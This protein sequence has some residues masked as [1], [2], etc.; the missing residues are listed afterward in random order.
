MTRFG[1]H[2]VLGAMTAFLVIA[3][4]GGD[5]SGFEDESGGDNVTNGGGTGG[6]NGSGQA[7]GSFDTEVAPTDPTDPTNPTAPTEVCATTHA[8]LSGKAH[9]IVLVLDR[10][11]S[12]KDPISNGSA[13]KWE[14]IQSAFTGFFKSGESTSIS[15]DVIPFPAVVQSSPNG[16][17]GY[18]YEKPAAGLST[19]LP[20]TSGAFSSTFSKIGVTGS[21]PT[22]AAMQGAI[23][24][25][26]A[27][28]KQLAGSA[29]VSIV[30]ATDGLPQG[31]LNKQTD[32]FF[33]ADDVAKTVAAGAGTVK[34]YVVGIGDQLESLNKIASAGGT[35][36][37]YLITGASTSLPK[38]LSKALAA[39]RAAAIG[40]TYNMPTPPQ[41]KTL[42]K[43]QVNVVYEGDKG[44]V[45]VKHSADCA[46]PNGWH[47]DNESAPT[48]ILLCGGACGTVKAA[49][50]TS[51]D[52]VLGCETNSPAAI[53][54]N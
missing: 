15:L 7:N 23:K 53:N 18:L 3:C 35:G 1:F 29:G 38:D 6:G 32:D 49:Q 37:A 50:V 17:D 34:T 2:T 22:N 8:G 45:L 12:M 51:L 30:L 21:T 10:S 13:S 44:K 39:I 28:K 5:G 26:S 16:C 31:C 36:Q 42:D 20:D 54:I 48:Q 4:S 11:A 24:Y 19:T 41:G 52:V 33:T 43:N 14:G 27:L 47:Y 9:H 25:A 40:C 46:D